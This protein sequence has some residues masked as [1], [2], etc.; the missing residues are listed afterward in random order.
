[1]R[2]LKNE[3]NMNITKQKQTHGYREKTSGLPAGRGK[4]EGQAWGSD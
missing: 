2:N 4:G 1:M 3:T